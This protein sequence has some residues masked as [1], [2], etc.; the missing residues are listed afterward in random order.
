[1][2]LKIPISYNLK[3]DNCTNIKSVE[4]VRPTSKF[5]AELIKD[6]TGTIV[7]I[8]FTEK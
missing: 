8:C 4:F 2:D 5:V 3:V 1:M 7:G 6:S